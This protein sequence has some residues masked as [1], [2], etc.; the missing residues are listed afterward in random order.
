MSFQWCIFNYSMNCFRIYY[1]KPPWA[2][3]QYQGFPLGNVWE[4][5]EYHWV[6]PNDYLHQCRVLMCI[7]KMRNCLGV[8]EGSNIGSFASPWDIHGSPSL[9]SDLNGVWEQGPRLGINLGEIL[10]CRTEICRSGGCFM[11]FFNYNFKCASFFYIFGWC[12][13][14]SEYLSNSIGMSRNGHDLSEI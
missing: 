13:S 8:A 4:L 6:S 12:E 5:L 10:N 9:E 2:A 1:P 14:P 7:F 11:Y 3:P